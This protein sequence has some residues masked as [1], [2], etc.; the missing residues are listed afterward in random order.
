MA[1]YCS[2][3]SRLTPIGSRTASLNSLV[4][5]SSEVYV[6]H[7]HCSLEKRAAPFVSSFSI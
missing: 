4:R 3:R 5:L 6:D 2:L 7:S 1:L